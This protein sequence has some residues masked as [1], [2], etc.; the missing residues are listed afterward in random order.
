M[1]IFYSLS[2]NKNVYSDSNIAATNPKIVVLSAV[3]IPTETPCIRAIML[4]WFCI[5]I[6]I[7]LLEAK[8]IAKPIMVP[9]NPK[10]VHS[11]PKNSN[12]LWDTTVAIM[13]AMINTNRIII[14]KYEA[15][16]SISVVIIPVLYCKANSPT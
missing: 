4:A 14:H 1:R 11:P 2:S 5:L 15:S 10:E 7:K 13:E 12:F 9:N 16:A 3:A 8:D 6:A